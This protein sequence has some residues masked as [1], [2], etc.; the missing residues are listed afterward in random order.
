V[1]DVGIFVW[2]VLLL[3][4]VVSSIASSARKQMQGAQPPQPQ[5][6]SGGPPGP[7]PVAAA[8]RVQVVVR[9]SAS[10]AQRQRA[11]QIQAAVA[12][13]LGTPLIAPAPA[14]IPAAPRPVT[15]RPAPAPAVTPHHPP[16]D[17]PQA[18]Q[19]R[20]FLRG[21]SEIVRAIV[22]AEVL[23][24]PRAFSDEYHGY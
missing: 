5:P 3:V 6:R 15:P 2:V 11:A 16:L 13:A 10:E 18:P 22:A 7:Q 1:R 14:P 8:P 4:G 21:R 19:M 20:P 12:Q 23:G 17:S 9:P 24:K